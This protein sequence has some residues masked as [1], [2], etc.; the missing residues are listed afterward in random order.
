[1]ITENTR[2]IDLTVGELM[3]VINQNTNTPTVIPSQDKK[4]VYGY[5]GIKELFNCSHK[6]AYELK[7]GVLKDAISQQ[8]RI[9]VVD[10]EKALE[11]FNTK[12]A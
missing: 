6:K 8:G 2:V 1:M 4:L 10:V 11:L 9:I 5:K 12:R 3:E 7:N